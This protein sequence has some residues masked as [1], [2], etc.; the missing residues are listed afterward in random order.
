MSSSR[1]PNCKRAPVRAALS[2]ARFPVFGPLPR[3]LE[4]LIPQALDPSNFLFAILN[5]I[6]DTRAPILSRNSGDPPMLPRPR[7]QPLSPRLPAASLPT[8][9]NMRKKTSR[10]LAHLEPL[11]LTLTR[12][13]YYLT[14]SEPAPN[15]SSNSTTSTRC[16]G[17]IPPPRPRDPVEF[18]R[19]I[20]IMRSAEV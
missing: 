1:N 10:K 14:Y 13:R 19:P 3:P 18:R 4:P 17:S 15:R 6:P 20:A 5:L 16:T 11:P 8:K 2:R 9:I 7:H 12:T